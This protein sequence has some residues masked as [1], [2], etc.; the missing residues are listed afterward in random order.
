VVRV[1]SLIQNIEARRCRPARQLSGGFVVSGGD[2]S[3]GLEL[4]DQA[5]DGVPL[6]VVGGVVADRRTAPGVLL[7]PVG[8]LV[9]LL[10]DHCLDV[11]LT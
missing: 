8:G 7:L 9:L 5:F 3:P 2:A 6:L 1:R 4:V 11:A 10:R